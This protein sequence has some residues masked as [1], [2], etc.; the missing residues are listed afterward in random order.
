MSFH[1]IHALA[2]VLLS[3]ELRVK[4]HLFLELTLHLVSN[5]QEIYLA[6]E[7]A[8][9]RHSFSLRCLHDPSNGL[10]QAIEV[11]RF[12][13]QLLSTCCGQG[14]IARA[15][16]ILRSAPLAFYPALQQEALQRGI[17]RSFFNLK[18]VVRYLL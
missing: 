1:R 7:L 10:D 5:Q 9:L 17:K 6:P 3:L 4:A 8:E 14:V 18:H 11:F 16:I 13:A 12:N 15:T 2:Q